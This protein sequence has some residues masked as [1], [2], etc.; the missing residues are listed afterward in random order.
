MVFARACPVR[1]LAGLP[2]LV[3]HRPAEADARA[4]LDSALTGPLDTR[5]RDQIVA[6][7]HGNP[8]ALLE[9]PRGLTPRRAGRRVRASRRGAV[10]GQHR[11]E[12][13]PAVDALPEQ[14][15]RL[16]LLA[17]AE[18]TGDPALVWRAAALLGHRRRRGGTRGRSRSGRVRH[19][20]AVPA[21]A[22]ALGG[23][24]VGRRRRRDSGRMA[25]WRRSPIP[26]LDAE[27]RA[28][29]RATPSPG[30]T[31]TS[32]PNWNAPPIGRK[33]GADWPRR[34]HSSSA[35]RC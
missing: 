16:L 4:L 11:G 22:G 18:P 28:W 8:L 9:L 15:R 2:E 10:H 27:R 3:G 35:P 26:T 32:P 25:R 21:S 13:P 12:F 24:P 30:R 29:H 33:R 5:V 31:R 23:L 1:E 19:A 6:E 7:T 34:R 17:A 14:T 20:S